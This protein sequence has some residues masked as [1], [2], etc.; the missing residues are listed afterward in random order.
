MAA[1]RLKY[2]Y[3]AYDIP[4]RDIRKRKVAI[5]HPYRLNNWLC[6]LSRRLKLLKKD[7]EHLN[8]IKDPKQRGTIIKG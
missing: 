2:K 7:K 8:T 1:Q 6:E 5:T 4:R 3:Y